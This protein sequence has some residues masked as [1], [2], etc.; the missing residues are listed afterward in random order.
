MTRSTRSRGL[1]AGATAVALLLPPG[2]AVAQDPTPTGSATAWLVDQLVDDDHLE[3]EFGPLYGPTADV[4]LALL[5]TGQ[6]PAA[7]EDVLAYLTTP[8][9]VDTY[10]HGGEFDGDTVDDPTYVGANAKLGYLVTRAGLDPRAVGGDDLVEGMRSLE[11]PD[12]GAFHDRSDFGDFANVL[13]HSF[14]LLFL[15]A[16]PKVDPSAASIQYLVDAQCP[17]G[18]F[19]QDFGGET[20]DSNVDAT[21]LALQALVAT[22]AAADVRTETVDFLLAQRDEDGAW[23]SGETGGDRNVNTTGYAG[24]G[25]LAAGG[26][27]ATTRQFLREVQNP[28]GGLPITPGAHS[29]AIATAQA[30]PLLAGTTL[31]AANPTTAGRIAGGDRVRT[32]IEA[33]RADYAD[34]TAGTVVLAR[35]DLFADALAG[36]PLAVQADGPLL[37]TA[38]DGLEDHVL[39]EIRRVLP[40]ASD[41]LVLGGHQALPESVDQDLRAA[42]YEPERIFGP[43]RFE[44]SV[45][46]ARKLGDPPLQLLT[47]GLDFAD[48]LTAGA[49]AAANDGAVLLTAGNAPDAPVTAYLDAHEGERVAVGGPAA[50]AHPDADELVGADREATAVLVAERFFDAPTA[51]GV[52]RLDLFADALA[53]GAV[54]ARRGGPVLLTATTSLPEVTS[55][56]LCSVGM[57]LDRATVLGGPAA[58]DDT[59]LATIRERVRDT[60]C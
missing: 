11:D 34:G 39:A 55:Q 50:A 7:L 25:L 35:S 37:I 13:G 38:P 43:S 12:T 60:G 10:V 40:E 53:G 5:A 54:M 46:I 49:A 41:V 14:A 6:Q 22:D 26:D 29:D 48:A 51:V 3:G 8:E 24:M 47:T 42:G 44:T 2:A 4:G 52:A 28:D 9:A 27:V 1:L 17:D 19:P 59:V 58:V 56:H 18:G 36:T 16:V 23:V 33:S 31:V 32:A 30:L 21:G 45:A 15:D 57:G 20:C